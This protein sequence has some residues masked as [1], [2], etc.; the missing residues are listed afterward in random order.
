MWHREKVVKIRWVHAVAW[1]FGHESLVKTT[2]F[3]NRAQTK[4]S[5]LFEHFKFTKLFID[6]WL[7]EL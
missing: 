3:T 4:L 5:V 2:L 6:I 7:P 1:C